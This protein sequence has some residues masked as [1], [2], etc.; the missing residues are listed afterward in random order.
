MTDSDCAPVRMK[1]SE[2]S[3]AAENPLSAWSAR[4]SGKTA[5]ATKRMKKFKGKMKRRTQTW[6]FSKKKLCAKGRKHLRAKVKV[7]SKGE[8]SKTYEVGC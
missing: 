6:S 2:A 7:E 8:A 3:W 4:G 5:D 1:P